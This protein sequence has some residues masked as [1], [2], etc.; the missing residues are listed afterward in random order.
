MLSEI[1][2]TEKD[3]YHMIFFTCGIYKNNKIYEQIK[4]KQTHRYREQ[5]D[6]CQMGGG[7]GRW[8]KKV[9]GLSSANCQLQK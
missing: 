5:T 4:Q 7:L 2:Q 3:K 6:D 8:V 9:K 1:S